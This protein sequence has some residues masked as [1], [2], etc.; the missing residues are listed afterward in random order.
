MPRNPDPKH[1]RWILPLIILAMVV[2]TITFVNSLE[3]AESEAGTTTTVLPPST[4]TTTTLPIEVTAFMVTLDVYETQAEAFLGDVQGIN[5]DWEGRQIT[6]SEAQASFEQVRANI[7]AWENEVA[8]A[9]DVPAAL[10]EAHVQLVLD[11][12]QL[13]PRVEDIILGL[14]APDDGTLRRAAMIDFEDQVAA[15]LDAIADLRD[16]ARQT[17]TPDDGSTTSTTSGGEEP[18]TSV[19]TSTTTTTAPSANA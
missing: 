2:L 6:Q 19:T 1:G 3:P 18:T 15:V 5:S 16:L 11:V 10:A 17:G 7:A 12:E 14:L 4:T 13:D 8:G 9:A